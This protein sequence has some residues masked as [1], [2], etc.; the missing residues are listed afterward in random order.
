[1]SPCDPRDAFLLTGCWVWQGT[2]PFDKEY[3]Q[4]LAVVA[5]QKA[6][7]FGTAELQA[8]LALGHASAEHPTSRM[9]Q[10]AHF[11]MVLEGLKERGLQMLAG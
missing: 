6:P 11:C 4:K 7:Y 10:Y 9:K 8:R 1:M 3:Q 5:L 2:I